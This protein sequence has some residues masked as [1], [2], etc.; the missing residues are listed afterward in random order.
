MGVP[1]EQTL[2]DKMINQGIAECAETHFAG[3]VRKVHKALLMGQCKHCK[4]L[5]DSLTR[6]ISEYLGQVDGR[7]KAVYQYEAALAPEVVEEDGL[8][9]HTGIHLVAW[10]ER[11]SAALSALTETLKVVIANSLQALG[12]PK[13]TPD[14]YTLDIEIVDARDINE[15]HGFGLLVKNPYL[16]SHLVW[17]R[18]EQQ[19]QVPVREE[20]SRVR[21]TLPAFFDPELIPE[22]RLLEHASSIERLSPEDRLGL[23]YHLTQLKVTLIRR[24]ISDQ[25]RYINIAKQWFTVADLTD[26]YQHRIGFGRIG[27][28]SAGMLLAGRILNEVASDALKASIQIPGSFFLGSD[29]MYIFMSMNGL[30]HWNDQKYKPEDQIRAEYP[31]IKEEFIAGEFP[32]EIRLELR[33]LLER[34]GPLPVIVRSSSQLEDNFGT[35]FA[36]KYDSHFCPNQGTTD[37]NLH[38]LTQAIASTYASTFK[39]DAL[40]Y[41]RSRGLQDYD[42]RMA[43]LIQV[44]QGEKV[45]RYYLPFGAGVAFSRNLYRWAP[46]IRR[47]AGFV[48]LV[49]GLGTRAV[50]RV[51]DDYPR[52]VA[53]SHPVLQPD[54]SPEAIRHYSQRYID[55]IDL[56]ENAVKTLPIGEVL[57]PQYP[58]IR[59]L[60]QLERDG[61]FVTPSSRVMQTDLPRLAIN[62]DHLL[63]RTSFAALMTELLR[64]LEK[65]YHSAVDAEF[66]AHIPDP[67]ALPPKIM[68]SLLQCR[69]QSSFETAKQVRLPKELLE[70]DIVFSSYFI[71]PQ[72]YLPNIRHVIFIPPE[73][74]FALPTESARNTIGRLIS[75]LNAILEKKTFICIG[76][77][78]WGTTNT[79]LG[80]FVG[81]ADICNAGAL[82]ELTGT[83]IGSAPEPSLG[84]HF[85]QDL[86]EAQIYPVAIRLDDTNTNFN[87]DF[88]YN[89][90]NRLREYIDSESDQDDCLRLIEVASFKTGHHLDLVMDD[91]KGQAVAFLAPDTVTQ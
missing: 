75:R 9:A 3:D 56:E 36:G 69:P 1:I 79:D 6:Q 23:E 41:R 43:V 81:Y 49:W 16:R 2:T 54:D 82:I 72:G 76:P 22:A 45:G 5:S 26:I 55:L 58:P 14:C 52:L 65:H 24:I 90:P 70:S 27:G 32:P 12:C 4:C 64:T 88:F 44:V 31:R 74:Y 71:V 83:G 57:T 68:I 10:V 67:L 21:F 87:H 91:E 13:A 53:L 42:E 84:T 86:M 77:G 15:R 38:A 60:V 85:F 50:E 62:Y 40:L 33:S 63:Q 11:K 59:F 39:P 29:L 7:V 80:V 20:T 25:L 66:T 30:M 37:E 48:R 19:E 89:T 73:K 17:Q 28:K 46:Q 47:E 34:I 35:S 8:K 51:G 78:R 18:F 61:Y